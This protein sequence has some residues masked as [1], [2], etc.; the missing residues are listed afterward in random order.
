MPASRPSSCDP[1]GERPRNLRSASVGRRMAGELVGERDESC[2]APSS[3]DKVERRDET[4]WRRTSAAGS[5]RPGVER[6]AGG[7]SVGATACAA[8]A[9]THR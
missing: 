7:V 8:A 4:S 2:V 9:V 3:Q 5:G 1:A 6:A